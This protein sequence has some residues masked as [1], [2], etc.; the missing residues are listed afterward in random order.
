V[1]RLR[2]LFPLLAVLLAPLISVAAAS[3]PDKPRTVTVRLHPMPE[4]RPA[5]KY[6]LLPPF[7]ERRPGNAAVWW[8]RIP[9]EQSRF[10]EDWKKAGGLEEK[11]EAWLKIPLSDPR[12]KQFREREPALSSLGREIVFADMDHAARFESCDWEVPIR[13]TPMISLRIPDLVQTRTYARL[14]RAKAHRE[15]AEGHSA[16]ALHT[17][18]TGLALARHSAQGPTLIHGLVGASIAGM[19]AEQLEQ[20]IQQPG[21]PN[22]YWAVVSLPTP[23]VDFRP[24]YEA[25]MNSLYLNFPELK[26]LDHKQL[27]AE[28]WR[29]LLQKFVSDLGNL[30][31]IRFPHPPALM[32]LLALQGYPGAKQHLIE[33]GRPAAEVEA[34]PVAQVVLLY[35]VEAYRE[36]SDEMFRCCFLPY[37]EG[38]KGFEQ[39]EE[40]LRRPSG[41][42]REIIPLA[43]TLLPAIGSVK[44]AETRAQLTF[45]R[46]RIL[47]A[48]RIYAAAH[49]GRLPERLSAIHEV[50]IPLNPYT[51]QPFEYRRDGDRAAMWGDNGRGEAWRYEITMGSKGVQR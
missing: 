23:V 6:Q 34:M 10:F 22:L 24:G 51:G 9:A 25:E 3:P 36:L 27:T 46:L 18:Q 29:E 2:K 42:S 5:L 28:Q 40:N 44:N 8:N 12:E 30:T 37:P 16:Q 4:A 21:A 11:V 13:E 31:D 14:L 48:L 50:P 20:F 45:A 35:T 43:A 1:K 49:D 17:I 47:E 7:L 38:R 33:H 19:M 26:D 41:R 39:A 15:I 32:V